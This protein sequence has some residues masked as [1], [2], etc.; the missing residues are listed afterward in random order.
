MYKFVSQLSRKFLASF[1]KS[2]ACH[3]EKARGLYL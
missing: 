1:D 3:T 2:A